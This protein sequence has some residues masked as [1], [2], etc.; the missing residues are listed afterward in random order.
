MKI[1]TLV[2]LALLLLLLGGCG[3]DQEKVIGGSGILEATE[4]MV[5]ALSGGTLT[6]LLVDE[7]DVVTAGQLIARIDSEK[8][9]LQRQQAVAGLEELRLNRLNAQRLTRTAREN[10]DNLAKKHERISALL[11]EGSATQQQF[12]DLDTALKA[13]E[14]QYENGRTSIAALDAREVQLKAQLELLASQLRDTRVTAPAGGVVIEK[15]LEAGELVRPGA[16]VVTIADLEHMFIRLYL[17]ETDLARIRLNGAARV[18]VTAFP[19]KNFSGR[20]AWISSR[21]EFTPKN[22][23]TKEARSD[24]VYAVKVAVTGSDGILKIGMPADVT[25]DQERP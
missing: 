19:G 22:V 24:L 15:Y 16:P 25:L 23:Q 5:S 2:T 3:Q 14:T 11:E 6:A 9:E 20:I 1:Q 10:R 13:A 17:N 7:G 8:V 18:E 4:I 21:A 12:D